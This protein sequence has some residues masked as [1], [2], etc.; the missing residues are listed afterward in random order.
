M[1]VSDNVR[2]HIAIHILKGTLVKVLCTE[3]KRSTSTPCQG[4]HGQLTIRFEKKQTEEE[5][6]LVEEATT[7]KEKEDAQIEVYKIRR[8]EAESLTGYSF[9]GLR[10]HGD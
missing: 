5:M 6:Q 3:V 9:K 7:K 2:R 4:N 8:N 1:I 10:L